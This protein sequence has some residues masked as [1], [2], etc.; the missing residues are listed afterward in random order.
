MGTGRRSGEHPS[1]LL[2][3]APLTLGTRQWRT[4]TVAD[5]D[6][7]LARFGA[8][9][10]GCPSSAY[11]PRSSGSDGQGGRNAGDEV[12]RRGLPCQSWAAASVVRP[13]AVVNGIEAMVITAVV[14]PLAVARRVSAP[15]V[16]LA[17]T[18]TRL[19]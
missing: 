7:E 16:R 1:P 5:T 10:R 14:R 18:N 19:T 4:L 9:V 11:S 3:T 13:P 17:R 15:A 6:L 8:R 2:A 12:D